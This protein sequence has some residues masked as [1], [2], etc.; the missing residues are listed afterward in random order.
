M[1]ELYFGLSMAVIGMG[2]TLFSL[3]IL[4]LVMNLLKKIF[5][6]RKSEGQF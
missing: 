1:E 3:W 4:S 6:Y 2:G 5:P